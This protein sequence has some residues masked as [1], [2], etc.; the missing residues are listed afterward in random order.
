MLAVFDDDDER[1]WGAECGLRVI[2]MWHMSESS[3]AIYLDSAGVASK[4][5]AEI[6]HRQGSIKSS[7]DL[8][9]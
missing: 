4:M 9:I 6:S 2:Y 1:K 5:Q 7:R 3:A 8:I